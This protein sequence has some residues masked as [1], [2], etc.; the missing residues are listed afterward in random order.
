VFTSL[1]A[2]DYLTV[3]TLLQLTPRLAANSH[4]PPTILT[5]VSRHSSISSWPLLYSLGTDRTENTS[6]NSFSIVVSR[7]YLTDRVEKT[8]SRLLHCCVLRICCGH[9]LATAV[10]YIAITYQ[11]L[12]YRCLFRGRCLATGLHAIILRH[13]TWQ[14]N[15]VHCTS[16]NVVRYP[17][18]GVYLTTF[19]KRNPHP[20]SGPGRWEYYS[21]RI[22]AWARLK[23]LVSMND[24]DI[25][26]ILAPDGPEYDSPPSSYI[27]WKKSKM[28]SKRCVF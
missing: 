22:A 24:L 1:L 27:C 15:N 18:Y 21:A 6:P 19:R 11:R 12:L 28:F 9:Y 13:W 10:V 26:S 16:I 17:L 20:S 2:G 4:Q 14:T 25:W 7:S 23:E 8:A 3:N 5:A